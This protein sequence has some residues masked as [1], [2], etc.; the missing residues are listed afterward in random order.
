MRRPCL[1]LQLHELQRFPYQK[2]GRSM[3]RCSGRSTLLGKSKSCRLL[4]VNLKMLKSKKLYAAIGSFKPKDR[5][6]KIADLSRRGSRM[7]ERSH[8]RKRSRKCCVLFGKVRLSCLDSLLQRLE[9]SDAGQVASC[10]IRIRQ[11]ETAM[12]N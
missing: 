11:R 8:K 7:S 12:R 3:T 5:S 4:C 9:S 6:S 10:I 2:P 1:Q